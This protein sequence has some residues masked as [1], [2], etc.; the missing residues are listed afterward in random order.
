MN[1]SR[2]ELKN[3]I[4]SLILEEYMPITRAVDIFAKY[5]VPNADRLDIDNLSKMYRTIARKVHP[6]VGGNTEQMKYVNIAYEVLKKN[7]TDPK[8]KVIPQRDPYQQKQPTVVVIDFYLTAPNRDDQSKM[9]AVLKDCLTTFNKM[10][11]NFKIVIAPQTRFLKNKKVQMSLRFSF[12]YN[13]NYDEVK[14]RMD[15]IADKICVRYFGDDYI[16]NGVDAALKHK[17]F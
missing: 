9:N 7:I 15:E 11:L 4:E 10:V 13:H 1:I 14:E 16:A 5:N 3:I 12:A 6:D 17:R 8:P 2:K